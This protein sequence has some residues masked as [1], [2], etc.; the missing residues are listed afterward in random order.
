M[1]RTPDAFE[2]LE[3]GSAPEDPGVALRW[4]EGHGRVFGHFI[5]GG[6]TD[7]SAGDT[8][9]TFNPA[10]TRPL[11]RVLEGT[12]GDVGDAVAAAR[13]AQPGWWALG[14]RGRAGYLQEL[15]RRIRKQAP[16]LAV[17]ESLDTGMTLRE[18]R[19][20]DLPLVARHFHHHA[21]WARLMD[22]ELPGHGP[23][24][25]V[26]Q[27]IPCSSPLLM[28][29]WKIAPALATGN[30]L[31]LKPAED[32]PLSA[33]W[34]AELCHEVGLPAGV[35][36]IVTGG[37]DTGAALVA[38]PDVDM[39]SFT[40]SSGVGRAIRD[41]TAGSGKRLALELGGPSP[42]IVFEDAD[43]DSAVEGVVDAIWHNQ[44]QVC[45]SG[46]RILVQEGVA[47]VFEDKLRARME[48]LSVGDPL[49][50]AVDVGAI[51]SQARLERI[52]ELVAEGRAGGADVWQP[53]GGLPDEGWFHPPTL[54]AGVSAADPVARAELL[55]PVGVLMTFRTPEEGVAL[56]NDTRY[57]LAASVWSESVN[58]A[59]DVA[60]AVKAG[61]VWV[62]CTHLFDAAS[63]FGG[64]RES[65]FGR[66][67]GKEGLWAYVSPVAESVAHAGDASPPDSSPELDVGP[68]RRL[69][70]EVAF[71]TS[72]DVARAVETARSAQAPWAARTAYE[73]GRILCHLAEIL[74]GQADEVAHGLALFS[75]DEDDAAR[76][77]E[78]TVS[79]LFTCGAWAD[80][81]DG[82]TY[83]TP[84]RILTLATYE[85]LG[86]V[87]V[88]CPDERPL[89]ALVSCVAPLVGLG[90][91]CVVIP[92]ECAPLPAT[93]LMG[94]M[95]ASDV[96]RGV[97]N[98]VTGPTDELAPTLA[99]HDD[100]D[101]VWCFGSR[102][103]AA[104][105]E[106]ESTGNLKR[107]WVE[108]TT[109]EDW[110]WS[111]QGQGEE[112]LRQST[113]LKNIWIPYGA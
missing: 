27:I 69:V 19:N 93:D 95:D 47:A 111:L 12:G 28:L 16:V 75:G 46:A 88:V 11:A 101:G 33:L 41:A 49:G 61:T 14:P 51:V 52:R 107:T 68:D 55:G 66:E 9:E 74:Q 113:Q 100:V 97:I 94:L 104:A 34:F 50:N 24:G 90:N 35:V 105:V 17:L 13:S 18:A 6:F 80:K 70:G 10:T 1:S 43:L 58:L 98:L 81:W 30:T 20:V 7:P 29:A 22:D 108:S 40:G 91:A 26:G 15:A 106:R 62:N 112:F 76:E 85:P 67:G 57:G 36:N 64:Y 78:A 110:T 32:A 99:A 92:S 60:S 73:R 63:G 4:L 102:S 77:V 48:T 39:I 65:G 103:R 82:R 53:S 56:A 87:G 71:G 23:I 89:L 109:P 5:A 44:G 25:V 86:V 21:G 72:R 42:F 83:A 2:T 37:S 8:L 54:C 31:V 59:L 38:H 96:P 45:A 84:F 79:R 3:Y